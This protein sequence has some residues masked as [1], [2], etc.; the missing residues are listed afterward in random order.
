MGQLK[1]MR[2]TILLFAFVIYTTCINA[3]VFRSI[4][5][6]DFQAYRFDNEYF[7][8]MIYQ[9]ST[10]NINYILPSQ[11]SVRF[12]MKN[13]STLMLNGMDMIQTMVPSPNNPHRIYY[14]KFKIS[15]EQIEL[16][17]DGVVCVAINTIPNVYETHRWIGRKSFGQKLY[18][19]FMDLQDELYYVEDNSED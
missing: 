4:G 14:V 15:M 18:K 2:K 10:N 7:L 11:V 17:K 6:V 12:K 3:M 8:I 16:F 19:D 9:E 1:Q 5:N 13:G